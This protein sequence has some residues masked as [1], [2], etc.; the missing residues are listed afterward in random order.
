MLRAVQ[1]TLPPIT[2]G[3]CLEQS[4]PGVIK[5]S[6]DLVRQRSLLQV[7]QVRLQLAQTAHANDDAV[8]A[9]VGQLEH[10]VVPH[11]AQGRLDQGQVVLRHDRFNHLEGR[12]VDVVEV[13]LTVHL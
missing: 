13:S 4:V 1:S 11:P 6:D 3:L 8:V 10:R 9:A 5:G 2:W 12:E 7:P